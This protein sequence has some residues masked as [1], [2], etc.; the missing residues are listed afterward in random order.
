MM[1]SIV[2]EV[3]KGVTPWLKTW[4]AK[5]EAGRITRPLRSKFVAFMGINVLML[6]R[7]PSDPQALRRDGPRRFAARE[8]L[9]AAAGFLRA[10]S[11]AMLRL[12]ASIRLTTF[13]REGAAG[14]DGAGRFVCFFFRMRM[15]A[16]L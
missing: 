15:S 7:W 9:D 6:S 5:R 2:G 14:G 10:G 12:S 3:E 4:N 16:F 11:A 8:A 13:S 1:D